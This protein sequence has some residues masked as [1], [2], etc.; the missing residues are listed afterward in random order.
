MPSMAISQ[1]VPKASI[2]LKPLVSKLNQKAMQLGE[3]YIGP[4]ERDGVVHLP[5]NAMIY[6]RGHSSDYDHWRQ[7]AT[8]WS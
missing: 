8:G 5:L 6:A 4:E 3:N 2:R 1:I 7:L